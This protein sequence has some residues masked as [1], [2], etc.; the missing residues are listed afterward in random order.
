MVAS[1]RTFPL[2]ETVVGPRVLNPP[3]TRHALLTLLIAL[4]AILHIGTAAWG[5]LYGET[6]GQYAG[7]AREMSERHDWMLPT[8]DGIPR[9]QKP[10][11]VYWL[12]LICY[13]GLGVNEAAARLPIAVATIGSV[14]VTFLI[15]ER[16]FDY[17]RGFLAGLM[18]LTF[19]G[20]FLLGR[21]IMPEPVFSALIAA[22]ILCAIAG[23]Q[24]QRNRRF[25]F[26]GFW[27]A[28]ALACVAKGLH[29]LLY[30]AAICGILAIFFREARLRFR[31]LLWWPYLLLFLAILVPWHAWC[32]WH[33][34]GFHGQLQKSEALVHV[35][36]R[37]DATRSYDNVP[38]LQFL[39]LHVAWWFPASLLILPGLIVSGRRIFRSLKSD[40]AEALPLCWAGVV[41]VPLLFLGQRQDYYSM[42]MWS[43]VAIL[44]VLAWDRMPR[45]LR[46]TGVGIVITCGTVVGAVALALPRIVNGGLAEWPATSARSTAWETVQAIPAATWLSLRPMIAVTAT[47]LIVC[48]LVA[49]YLAS[50]NRERLALV[51]MLAAMIPIGLLAI[52]GVARLAPFF[53]LANAAR[54]LNDRMTDETQL[55]YEG[56][57]HT[58]SSLVFYLDSE[59]F[60]VN[61]KPEPFEAQLGA[62]DKYL[63]ETTLLRAWR[64]ADPIYLIVE[65]NRLPYWQ[66]V[67]TERVHIFH[68]VATCGTYV[69]LTNQL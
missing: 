67:I 53:S 9:L 59:F 64:N 61:Q 58:G 65:Q 1:A 66:R 8:N 51:V 12:I 35:L 49:F 54:F 4:A 31:F 2:H 69:V 33:F 17:W 18:H 20:T 50:K 39:A 10:P 26:A 41:F 45:S 13:K 46:L 7:A 5:D 55:F 47:A 36:G 40:L 60:L 68:Q 37:T 56:S 32:A 57:M 38:Q 28:T 23:Y 52:D 21:I 6:D 15:A 24:G 19:A 27:I 3:P 30:P 16:L 34:P 29:G 14:A 48:G 11:L 62:A 22:A 43:A 42:N 44:G 63:S 25:W